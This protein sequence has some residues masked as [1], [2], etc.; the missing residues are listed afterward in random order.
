MTGERDRILDENMKKLLQATNEPLNEVFE[1]RL[2]TA[3][4]AAVRE[5]R[6]TYPTRLMLAA[7]ACL[8]VVAGIGFFFTVGEKA[9]V[10]VAHNVRGLTQIGELDNL[11]AMDA[12]AD[13]HAGDWIETLSGSEA[14][15]V[16]NDGS[17]LLVQPHTLFQLL[18]GGKRVDLKR[19]YVAIE[20]VKQPLN[21][22]ISIKTDGTETRVLGTTLNVRANA[23]PDTDATRTRVRV[24]SGRVDFG[25]QTERYELAPGVEGLTEDGQTVQRR[26]L[27]PEINDLIEL[28]VRLKDKE[29]DCA[30]IFDISEH[31]EVNV[32]RTLHIQ[33]DTKAELARYTVDA[34]IKTPGLKAFSSEGFTLPIQGSD[35]DLSNAPLAPGES[36]T[37]LLELPRVMGRTPTVTEDSLRYS[38]PL[39]ESQAISFI[40]IRLPEF[41]DLNQINLNPLEQ[42]K[43]GDRL[44][45]TVE[46]S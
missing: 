21:T 9:P 8:L 11:A 5:R 6:R 30:A 4:L 35:V 46:N 3:V 2:E 39:Q 20:A 28:A 16:L 13:V 42:H 36:R 7:A 40:Q 24:T 32:W 1:S 38:L 45:V 19:G 12:P 17:R 14:E 41:M 26:S 22:H 34:A 29:Q 27:I 44:Y 15:V 33:N 18:D 25:T 37:I 43:V 10:G 23:N 31:G